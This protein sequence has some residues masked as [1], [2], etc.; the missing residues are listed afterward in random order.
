MNFHAQISRISVMSLVSL[1][2][3][4][5]ENRLGFF[6][7]WNISLALSNKQY[8]CAVFQTFEITAFLE[9][10]SYKLDIHFLPQYLQEKAVTNDYPTV[11]S[12]SQTMCSQCWETWFKCLR[13]P[14]E[15][16]WGVR[17]NFFFLW[18]YDFAS[19]RY[20]LSNICTNTLICMD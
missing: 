4:H 6:K 9:Q 16:V 14:T 15:V 12:P 13:T 20:N 8:I 17:F 18:L 19:P 3:S 10:M 2:L 11:S 7:S 1:W 5:F